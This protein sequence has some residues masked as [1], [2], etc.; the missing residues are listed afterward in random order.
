MRPGR[1]TAAVTPLSA[2]LITCDEEQNLPRALESVKF[3][4]EVV[5]LDGGSRD[6]TRDLAA[7]AGARVETSIPWPGFVEQRNRAVAA[8][9]HDWVLAIDADERVT[10]ELRD[11]IRAEAARGFAHAGYRIPRLAFYLGRWIR[12]TDWWPDPQLRLFDR[13]RGRW[14]GNLIHESVRVDGSVGRLRAR[15]EHFSYDDISDH[16]ATIDRYT[17]LWAE[18]AA[19]EGQRSGPLDPTFAAAWA[20]FR[21]Y[22]VR[23]GVLLGE[24]GLTVSTLNSYYTYVKL[25]K[26]RERLDGAALPPRT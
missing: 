21:N 18:Q 1:Y 12:G 15:M 2:V 11:E 5:V 10:A 14:E 20:F 16:L 24:A 4:D 3:C 17:T 13:R 8:A 26:L 19:Q 9:S 7:A 23:R 6:R 25:A 22:V